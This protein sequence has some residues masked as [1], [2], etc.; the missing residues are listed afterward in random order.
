[1]T[2]QNSI[3]LLDDITANRIAAGE[4]VERPASALKELIENAIDAQARHIKIRYSDGGKTFFEVRDDGTGIRASELSL[5]VQRHATSKL[6]ETS[7]E[8]ITSFGFRGEALP[9]IGAVARLEILSKT[10]EETGQKI[11]IEAG[12]IVEEA[13]VA[14]AIGTTVRVR[15]IFFATP[16]RL[17]FQGSDRAESLAISDT[18]K[19]LAMARPD[20]GFSLYEEKPEGARKIFDFPALAGDAYGDRITAILGNQ[21]LAD[22]LPFSAEKDGC[23]IW[24][25][26]GLP[27]AAKGNAQAQYFY[28]NGRPLKD[29]LF[30]GAVKGAYSDVL[31]SGKFPFCVIYMRIDPERIDVN[32]HPAKT[33]IRFKEAASIRSF[34]LNAV[35]MGLQS[36]PMQADHSLSSA[37]MGQFSQT[38]AQPQNRPNFEQ[39]REQNGMNFAQ[40]PSAYQSMQSPMRYAMPSLQSHQNLAESARG[41]EG[42]TYQGEGETADD[43]PLGFARAQ[44]FDNYIIAQNSE[45][46]IIIDAHAAH[47]RIVYEKL[48]AQYESREVTKQRLLIPE[49]LTLDP[50][51][52]DQIISEKSHFDALGL[53]IEDFG[54]DAIA[55]Q[56]VPSLLNAQSIKSLFEEIIE[57][58]GSFKTENPVQSHLNAVLSSMACHGSVRSGRR[59]KLEE[60]NALLREMEQTPN[61]G[62][63][64]HGR[65]TFITL[66]RQALENRFG[67]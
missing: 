5:A 60:M 10:Q 56:A 20:I 48:K 64:N 37:L 31:P 2:M 1:M 57:A 52:K 12:K 54:I 3:R 34:V 8:K 59:L 30:Y 67:R 15:D 47:E 13:P 43:Y 36:R 14:H 6:N 44:I 39:S 50:V 24:G 49:I 22:G 61:A 23:Q 21:A 9:S 28:V 26:I 32:V 27:T 35:R 46:L 33:E 42:E 45:G 18:V 53:E 19:R 66:D 65:P 55:I 63:C 11:R 38:I 58:I 4:V 62:S 16:A 29:K 17:K 7:L 25:Y 51:Q 40:R 41:F